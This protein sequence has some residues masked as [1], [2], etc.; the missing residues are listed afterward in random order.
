M[1]GIIL[2]IL[3]FFK[4]CTGKFITPD[5]LEQ[6][7][8]NC[9][10]VQ[11]FWV[12][13]EPL[14]NCIIGVV[15]VYPEQFM[16]IC[17]NGGVKGDDFEKLIENEEAKKVFLTALQVNVKA[18]NIIMDFEIAKGIIIEPISFMDLGMYTESGKIKRRA[19]AQRYKSQIEQLHKKLE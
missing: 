3:G 12:Y 10:G 2:V 6:L 14:W 5:R 7:Y 19:L 15:N 13:G 17:R 16:E 18:D 11:N 4:L 9:R 1:A 8:K